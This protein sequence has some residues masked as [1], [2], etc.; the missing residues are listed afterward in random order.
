MTLRIHDTRT[1]KKVP[2]EPLV[3]GK[4]SLYACGT[5][6]YDLC[7]IGHARKEVAWDVIT[8]HLRASFELRFVRNI[9]DVDDKIINKANEEKKSAAEVARHY[10][11]EMNVDFRALGLATPDLE[12]RATDHIAEM[13]DIIRRLEEKGLAY[14]AGGDVYYAV[15]KFAGYG[16]LSG[17]C[18]DDMKA[19]AR[20]EVDEQKQSPLDFA[21]WKGAKPGEPFWPSPWGN[22]RPGWHIECSAMSYRYL[23]EQ[24]DIHG[25]GTDLIFPHHE[26]EIAQ[27]E[28]AFG[29]GSFA[30][31]WIH[32]GLL[33]LDGVKMSKSLGNIIT[34][35]KVMETHDLEA[36]RLLYLGVHYRSTVDFAY[37]KL[38]EAEERLEYFYTTL[39]RLA[40]APAGDDKGAVL[41]EAEK[42][43]PVFQEAM[44]DDFN[45]AGAVGHLYEAFVLANRLLEDPKAAPKD[46]RRRT[47]AR[48]RRDLL[49]CGETLGIFQRGP[50]AF[51][52][53]RRDRQCARL[54]IDA[55]AVEAR[56]KDRAAARAA[57]D[58]ARADEI[59]RELREQRIELMDGPT[60]TTWRVV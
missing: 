59:R 16:Q 34:I 4:V 28:G 35:R 2:F 52:L 56:I 44:D 45:A 49:K 19:G 1:G 50:A 14:A 21:L 18:I 30:R 40:D 17:Q 51:L 15:P 8:R 37:Q 7:H 38:D 54:G 23:G 58:F 33:T 11:D 3:P 22:G 25:G 27:S 24:F 12:P 60:G 13:I 47:L 43:L 39:A 42:T 29:A 46:V 5:T 20:V 10:T 57:K 31:H 32:S 55:P 6:V 26:N 48:L 36:L 53:A 41:P 9:T